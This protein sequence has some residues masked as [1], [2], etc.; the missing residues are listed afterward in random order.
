MQNESKTAKESR[1]GRIGAQVRVSEGRR[2]IADSHNLAAVLASKVTNL[3]GL[4]HRS[5]AHDEFTTVGR[6]E[7]REGGCAVAVRWDGER[8]D[9]P[10]ER[11]VHGL[12]G[13]THEV[14]GETRAIGG[15]YTLDVA[16]N[17]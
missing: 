10:V 13:E 4:R 14:D 9:V 12:V 5:V 7:M 17:G 6:V 3:A 1:A 15:S 11:S 8:V 2:E 16:H